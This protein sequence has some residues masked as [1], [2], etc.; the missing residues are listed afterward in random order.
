[1]QGA[2]VPSLLGE[3]GPRA[4]TKTWYSQIKKKKNY[5]SLAG[6]VQVLWQTN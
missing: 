6:D 1:M 5:V 2:R 4:A 3:L